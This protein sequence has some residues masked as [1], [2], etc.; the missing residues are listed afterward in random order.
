M[1]LSKVY[2]E[3]KI[4]LDRRLLKNKFWAII[5]IL[6]GVVSAAFNRDATFLIFTLLFGIP[7]LFAKENW[8]M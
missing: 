4:L 3:I 8:I 6:T 1:F 2:D 7:L 5:I